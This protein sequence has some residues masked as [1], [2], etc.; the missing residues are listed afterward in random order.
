MAKL[1]DNKWIQ[2]NYSSGLINCNNS[3]TF[4]IEALREI[5]PYFNAGNIFPSD[6]D[7]AKQKYNKK[8]NFLPSNIKNELINYIKN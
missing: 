8:L 5:K 4:I 6:P 3:H 2:S 1:E 7:L